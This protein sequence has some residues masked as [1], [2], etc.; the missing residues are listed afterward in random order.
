MIQVA[1]DD[2]ECQHKGLVGVIYCL[3]DR[4]SGD[5]GHQTFDKNLIMQVGSFIRFGAP[6]RVMG[7]HFVY[8]NV[9][10]KFISG[11][12]AAVLNPDVR[13][14]FLTHFGEITYRS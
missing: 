10:S 2:I 5:A 6:I 12:I 8:N 11:N 13:R 7:L 4:I 3:P 1:S 14:L 9:S